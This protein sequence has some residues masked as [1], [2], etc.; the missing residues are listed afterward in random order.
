M[1]GAEEYIIEALTWCGITPD[2]GVGFGGPHEPYRQSER[3]E[4]GFYRQYADQ[5]INSEHAYIAFDTPTEL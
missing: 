2:E 3:K 4:K 5:L 1:P